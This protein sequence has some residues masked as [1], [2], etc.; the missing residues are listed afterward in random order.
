MLPPSVRKLVAHHEVL[1]ALILVW[2][3]V[4][5]V[6]TLAGFYLG[7]FAASEHIQDLQG[8]DVDNGGKGAVIGFFLALIIAAVT[9]AIYPKKIAREYELR[10]AS[11]REPSH[12][13]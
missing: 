13:H 8:H 1:M 5:T 7:T 12:H 2:I 6:L 9:S 4:P 11:W 3:V 10:E